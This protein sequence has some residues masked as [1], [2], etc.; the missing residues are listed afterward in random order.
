MTEREKLLEQLEQISN[1]DDMQKISDKL[2]ALDSKDPYGLFLSWNLLGG[3]DN[4]EKLEHIDLLQDTYST[5]HEVIHS[6]E[7]AEPLADRDFCLFMTIAYSLGLSFIELGKGDEALSIARDMVHH[8]E[9]N[10]FN[11]RELLYA[12]MIMLEM[13]NDILDFQMNDTVECLAGLYTQALALLQSG[14]DESETMEAFYNAVAVA[15]K[16]PLYILGILEFDEEEEI[17]EIFE[18]NLTTTIEFLTKIWTSNNKCINLLSMFAFPFAYIRGYL[19]DK[20][21]IN[22]LEKLYARFDLLDKL[23]TL[24][25]QLSRSAKKGKDEKALDEEAFLATKELIKYIKQ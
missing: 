15:P 4:R 1:L 22:F 16:I 8:D 21:E 13:W 12:S 7:I 20:E 9:E 11:S 19:K 2:L 14:D 10:I 5:M 17:T 23:K 18:P 25:S 6:K 3:D 24:K